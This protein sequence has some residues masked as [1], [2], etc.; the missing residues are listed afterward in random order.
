LPTTAL[1]LGGGGVTGVAWELGLLTGLREAGVDL[2]T[3][4]L[5]VGTSAGAVVA[6]L[7]TSG[8]PLERAYEAQL[9]GPGAEV[10][11][12]MGRQ[13]LAAW[14]WAMLT[15]RDPAAYRARIGRMALRAPTVPEAARR[16]IIESRLPSHTWPERPLLITAVDAV[17]GE[18]VAFD[19][20]SGVGLVDAVGAS[21]AVPG[22]W[23]PVTINGRRWIDGGVRGPV[24]ADLAGDCERIVVIAPITAGFGPV[25]GPAA[26]VA[27]LAKTADVVMISPDGAASIAIG[28]NVLDPA[29]RAPA[30]RAG[31]A[32][33]AAV[34]ERVG[35]LWNG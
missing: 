31:H 6:A 18:F 15:T 14:M 13:A 3:A 1:V 35:S 34:A 23:P 32:Q 25:A 21:C 30:A 7:L 17:S 24:N 26:Q 16:A 29:R 8:T 28:R 20:D 9:A 10:A 5:V 22:V 12:R 11:A 2:G 27:R 19:R 4:G 33:A